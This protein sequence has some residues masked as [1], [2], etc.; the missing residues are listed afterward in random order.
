MSEQG[1][2]INARHLERH[3]VVLDQK[4]DESEQQVHLVGKKE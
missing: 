4:A 3:V 2:R 1:M